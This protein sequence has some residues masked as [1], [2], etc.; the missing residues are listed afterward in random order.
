[1]SVRSTTLGFLHL[2]S[3]VGHTDVCQGLIGAHHFKWTCRAHHKPALI[4][5]QNLAGLRFALPF[6]EHVAAS[7]A[8]KEPW[9]SESFIRHRDQRWSITPSYPI[10]DPKLRVRINGGSPEAV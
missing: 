6:A 2:Q 10:A 7:D 8:S 4:T 1:M 9:I 3:S 5:P